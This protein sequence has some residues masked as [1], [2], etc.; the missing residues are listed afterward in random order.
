MQVSIDLNHLSPFSKHIIQRSLLKTLDYWS[1]EV[2]GK[3]ITIDSLDRIEV[4][5]RDFIDNEIKTKNIIP[6]F[7]RPYWRP[8]RPVFSDWR[9]HILS[10]N[11]FDTLLNNNSCLFASFDLSS[12]PKQENAIKT[13]S[14]GFAE[15]ELIESENQHAFITETND[16]QVGQTIAIRNPSAD[17]SIIVE[18]DG[19]TKSNTSHFINEFSLVDF[20]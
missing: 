10:N 11:F 17:K 16:L 5:T 4:K 18:I 20:D 8:R 12:E 2:L 13:I 19:V 9:D 6:E 1:N 14:V 3:P 15:F 7:S